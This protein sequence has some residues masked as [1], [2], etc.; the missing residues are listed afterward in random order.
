MRMRPARKLLVASLGVA[1]VSYCGG[2]TAFPPDPPVDASSADAAD[3]TWTFPTVDAAPPPNDSG[4]TYADHIVANVA[5]PPP[6]NDVD[7][8]DD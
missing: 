1:A 5:P 8:G 4:I 7:S 3:E 6:D 2:K